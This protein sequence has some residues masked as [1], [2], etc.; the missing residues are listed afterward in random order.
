M[1]N[2]V[3]SVTVS[4]PSNCKMLML[5]AECWDTQEQIMYHS[6]AMAMDQFGWIKYHVQVMSHQLL[7]ATQPDGAI[8]TVAIHKML[9]LPAMV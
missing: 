1:A 2:G 6:M 7:C 3:Q 4:C 5:S 8:T 9:V